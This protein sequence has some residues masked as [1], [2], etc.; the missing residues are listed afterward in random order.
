MITSNYTDDFQYKIFGYLFLENTFEGEPSKKGG[1]LFVEKIMSMLKAD[2]FSKNEIRH[3]FIILKNYFNKYHNFP[4]TKIFLQ[5]LKNNSSMDEEKYEYQKSVFT[6]CLKSIKEEEVAYIRDNIENNIR[7]LLTLNAV[8]KIKENLE[9][10]K[11]NSDKDFKKIEAEIIESTAFK[12]DVDEDLDIF[13]NFESILHDDYR[14]PIPTG[15]DFLDRDTRG[16]LAKGELGLVM[17]AFGVG[18][19]TILS[20]IANTAYR[21]NFNVVQIVFEDKQEEIKSKH[22]AIFSGLDSRELVKNHEIVK[23]SIMREKQL[24]PSNHLII[25]RMPSSNSTLLTI[26]NFLNKVRRQYNIEIDLLI[27][28][29]VDCL[30]GIK[31]D[32][33]EGEKEVMRGLES[34]CV[35]ENIAIWAA[36][37]ANRSGV[38]Q[39]KLTGHQIGGSI[40]KGQI[41]HLFITF[42]KDEDQKINKRATC[43]FIKSRIGKDGHSYEDIT[44]DNAKLIISE[45]EVTQT[46]PIPMSD[47]I[48][49]EL[50]GITSDKEEE[51]KYDH[52]EE[53]NLLKDL[54]QKSNLFER[55][56]N[57]IPVNNN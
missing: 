35:D 13:D 36:T 26:K 28:D 34:M 5:E 6:K 19:T 24:H 31:N 46:L 41:A 55:G 30:S 18:K 48:Y 45:T 54:M 50:H 1:K 33:L 53:I 44:F 27:V 4:D 16:G 47:P 37:Q 20:K 8:N 10:G 32:G 11:I 29:Y 52:S 51:S 15:I 3:L 56:E 25:K 57:K 17:C 22:Y 23:E 40:A 43:S 21:E 12:L 42:G 38:D 14:K 7:N 9:Q 49:R 39:S 2:I